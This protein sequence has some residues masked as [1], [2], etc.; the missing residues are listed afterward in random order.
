MAVAIIDQSQ[1]E[2]LADL[3]SVACG[4]RPTAEMCDICEVIDGA[5]EAASAATENDSFQMRL[6]VR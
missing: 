5:S 2:F 4:S 6:E 3:N 1:R